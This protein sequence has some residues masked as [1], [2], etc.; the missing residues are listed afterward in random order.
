MDCKSAAPIEEELENELELLKL[1]DRPER[2]DGGGIM[3]PLV[4]VA[5]KGAGNA[6][7]LTPFS[8]DWNADADCWK[9]N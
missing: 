7:M 3:N 8:G 6:G 2:S 9:L 5:I 4:P 1:L